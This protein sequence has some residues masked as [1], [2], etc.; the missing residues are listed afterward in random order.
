MRR[1]AACDSHVFGRVE[2]GTTPGVVEGVYRPVD[3]KRWG[4]V[5]PGVGATR[6]LMALITDNALP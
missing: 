2:V 3:L 5:V 4:Q 6:V 1:T